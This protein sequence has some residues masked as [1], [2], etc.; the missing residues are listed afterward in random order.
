[1]RR[2]EERQLAWARLKTNIRIRRRDAEFP[3]SGRC[4]RTSARPRSCFC[5]RCGMTMPRGPAASDDAEAGRPRSRNRSSS[6]ASASRF[7]VSRRHWAMYRR[8]AL[9]SFVWRP[10]LRRLRL[11]SG[12]PTRGCQT[13]C[14]RNILKVEVTVARTG[15][16]GL[17][18]PA[19]GGPRAQQSDGNG[20]PPAP[21]S[22]GGVRPFSPHWPRSSSAT[23]SAP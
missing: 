19:C 12:A 11:P 14:G 5:I 8:I 21:G 13:S 17:A 22:R 23:P 4:F 3:N 1:M 7:L 9:H 6:S 15:G 16:R 10:C 18:L 20:F 2:R